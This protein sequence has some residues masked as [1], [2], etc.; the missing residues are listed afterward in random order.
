MPALRLGEA[1]VARLSGVIVVSD[2]EAGLDHAQLKLL[3]QE[4]SYPLGASQRRIM[5]LGASE[6]LSECELWAAAAGVSP[7][8][9]ISRGLAT[10][11]VLHQVT[12]NSMLFSADARE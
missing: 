10:I 5:L 6:I 11:V 8:A 4:L 7:A 2:L 3:D 1:R 12:R 9:G